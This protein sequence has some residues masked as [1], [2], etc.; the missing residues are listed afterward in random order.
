MEWDCNWSNA[1]NGFRNIAQVLQEVID[2]NSGEV[3][4]D[5]NVSLYQLNILPEQ[6][7]QSTL[8]K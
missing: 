3:I 1:A 8:V 6:N 4:I 7:S 2:I 5:D